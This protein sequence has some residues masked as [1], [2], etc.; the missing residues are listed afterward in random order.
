MRFLSPDI[1]AARALHGRGISKHRAGRDAGRTAGSPPR[2]GAP[3]PIPDIAVS[4]Q[5]TSRRQ[6]PARGWGTSLAAGPRM[7]GFA[8]CPACSG[9][10]LDPRAACVHCGAP[11]APRRGLARFLLVRLLGVASSVT[12]MACYGMTYDCPNNRCDACYDDADCASGEQCDQTTGECVPVTHWCDGDDDCPTGERC[13]V[14]WHLCEPAGTPCGFDGA[15]CG[16]GSR[17]DPVEEICVPCDAATGACGA[18][19]GEVT[20]AAT[21]PACPPGT[22][23]AIEA[24]CYT[25]ACIPDATCVA[26]ACAAH[27]EPA[28]IADPACAPVYQGINCTNPEGDPCTTDPVCT[29]ESYVFDGCEPAPPPPQ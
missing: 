21:P 24:G 18:C 12:L 4:I 27:D 28:C 5:I 1:E 13:D 9:F 23:P 6:L 29:C 14:E 11:P 8:S 2:V 3:P 7:P 22:Q 19:D 26:L 10:I 17:C 20:C 25:A 16:E 15:T